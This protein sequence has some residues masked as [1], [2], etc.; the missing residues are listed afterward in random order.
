MPISE[1]AIKLI[2]HYESLHDG[3]LKE[4]GIQPKMDPVGIWTI[5]WGHAIVDPITRQFVR[6]KENYKRA[7]ELF[8][9][10]DDRQADDLF[11]RD[12]SAF[13]KAVRNAVKPK[14]DDNQI[15][16]LTSF[17]YNV[18]TGSFLRSSALKFINQK[19]IAEAGARLLVWNKAKVNGQ[20]VELKGLTYRRMSER[21]LL[22]TG[23]LKFYNVN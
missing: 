19:N 11:L 1:N 13:E 8:P 14:L 6:G 10:F 16:A 15:G 7:L 20:L 22:V 21:D 18:G 4:L 2:K 17:A 9:N 12:I 3:N 23:V 5:G